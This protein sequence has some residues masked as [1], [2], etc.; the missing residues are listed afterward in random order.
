MLEVRLLH[1]YPAAIDTDVSLHLQVSDAEVAIA[2]D[3]DLQ[4]IVV[5]I[6]SRALSVL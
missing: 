3:D 1:R 6:S 4:S 5:R 2:S